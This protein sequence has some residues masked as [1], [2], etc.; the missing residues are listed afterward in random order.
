MVTKSALRAS[1]ERTR[2]LRA[3]GV[4]PVRNPLS[5]NKNGKGDERKGTLKKDISQD[6]GR[7]EGSLG[8]FLKSRSLL[9]SGAS[10]FDGGY[11]EETQGGT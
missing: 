8:I 2:D 7:R 4:G 9:K 3:K 5:E 1:L 11:A 6:P 10:I